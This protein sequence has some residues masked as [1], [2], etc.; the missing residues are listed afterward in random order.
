MTL[1]ANIR[2][3]EIRTAKNT[4]VNN[5]QSWCQRPPLLK[6]VKDN[7]SDNKLEKNHT[8]TTTYTSR[9]YI[10]TTEPPL[11]PEIH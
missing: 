5:D 1:S 10:N 6:G 4:L 8:K 2:S 3:A 11:L 9:Y 7:L